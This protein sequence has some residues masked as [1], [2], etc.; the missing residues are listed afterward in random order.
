MNHG[1][2]GR[3]G[4]FGDTVAVDLASGRAVDL[5]ELYA[6]DAVTDHERQAIEDYIST[7]PEAERLAFQARVRQARETLART[8]RVEEEP[9]ADLF[10]RIVAQLPPKEGPNQDSRPEAGAPV[11]P[12]GPDASPE[13][14]DEL[15]KARQR[16]KERRR[17]G[18]RRWLAGVAAAA[19]IALG[20]VGVGSY[21]ADQNDPLNQVVRAADLREASVEVSGG[22]TATLLISSSEDAAVVKMNGVPA[23]PEGKV[24]QMWLI[25]KDGSAPVSQGLMD[26]E[27]LSKPAVVEGISSA[28]A[29]GI[30]VEPVGGSESPTLPT[31]AAAPLGA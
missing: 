6:L 21:L 29:L 9:P 20:G 18:A 2:S 28:A 7:A 10:K 14:G 24:Y 16:R 22:G 5:A 15:A 19:A 27:A 25:P 13:A 26:E 3:S 12:A 17:P 1:P 8:F 4:S 23:P 31:V 11:P 30:T